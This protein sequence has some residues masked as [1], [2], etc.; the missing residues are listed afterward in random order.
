[1][2]P[3]VPSPV[4]DSGSLSHPLYLK[5]LGDLLVELVGQLVGKAAAHQVPT[6]VQGELRVAERVERAGRSLQHCLPRVL[7][8]HLLQLPQHQLQVLRGEGAVGGTGT[9]RLP[10]DKGQGASHRDK[11]TCS[12]LQGG[13]VRVRPPPREEED[14]HGPPRGTE[15][16]P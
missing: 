7:L 9:R 5:Q 3:A 4:P 14:S 2:T 15:T 1:M 12:L 6:A 11:G 16:A 13:M 10:R 8:H